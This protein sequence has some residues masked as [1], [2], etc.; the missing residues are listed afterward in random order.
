MPKTLGGLALLAL[1]LVG[2]SIWKQWPTD[3]QAAESSA[4]IVVLPFVDLTPEKASQAFCDGL[5]EE[6]SNRLSQIANLQVVARTS[7]LAF[8]GQ[9]EDV[10][11]IGKALD[12]SHVLEG[13]V[14]RSGNNMRVTVHLVDARN[15]YRLWSAHYDAAAED[16]I[17]VQEDISQ[18]VAE[19]LQAQLAIAK[20]GASGSRHSPD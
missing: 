11:T 9:G 17:R 18:S 2:A 6:L 15:G 16:V 1:M 7:A 8:R 12:T 14:R 19:N 3:H 20:N 13:S 5:T 10:R 4:S